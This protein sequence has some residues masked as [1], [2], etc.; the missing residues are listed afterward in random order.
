MIN[1]YHNCVKH[2]WALVF[3]ACGGGLGGSTTVT[4]PNG[5]PGIGFDD[6]RSSSLGLIVPGGRSGN[7]YVVRPDGAVDTI[8]GGF[9]TSPK[10]EGGHGFGA[11]SADEAS[12]GLLLVTDRTTQSLDVV[13]PKTRAITTTIPLAAGPD[14]VRFVGSKN[15]A[16]VAEPDGS[17]IE[18]VSLDSMK[19]VGAIPI[20]NGPESMEADDARHRVYVHR[21]QKSTLAIDIDKRSIAEEWANGCA[22]SRGL[23][24]DRDRGWV[25]AGCLEGTMSVLD[26]NDHGRPLGSIAHGSGFDVI[27]YSPS[28]RHVY[29]V[30]FTCKCLVMLGLSSKGV[31]SLL[32]RFDAPG[33][34]SCAVADDRGHAWVC[35]PDQGVL[36]RYD[37]RHPALP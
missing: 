30:G 13:D 28:L 26:A 19:S 9:S 34:G 8:I 35:G 7:V 24:V 25:I 16:W 5:A 33:D 22:A 20:E 6:L 3:A 18:I 11:T 17:Q 4:L 1:D 14:Y 12:N 37:D 21:W 10:H 23:A 27:G 15:E 31:P 2:L 29:M 32:E 36:H